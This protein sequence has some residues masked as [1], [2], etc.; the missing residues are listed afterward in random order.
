MEYRKIASNIEQH[1]R[2]YSGKIMQ[3]DSVQQLKKAYRNA[4]ERA[5]LPESGAISEEITAL[6]NQL[7]AALN[8]HKNLQ[9][10]LEEALARAESLTQQLEAETQLRTQA[11]AELADLKEQYAQLESAHADAIEEQNLEINR[12]QRKLQNLK[13]QNEQLNQELC[14]IEYRTYGVCSHCGGTFTGLLRKKCSA[15]GAQKDY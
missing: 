6:K 8:R 11:E 10:N 7:T 15:C 14:S 9:A 12:L 4:A 13:Q 1:V 2:T 5:R 3:L